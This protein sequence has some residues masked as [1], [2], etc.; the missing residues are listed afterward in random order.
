MLRECARE[1]KTSWGAQARE[2]AECGGRRR[3][4]PRETRQ[5]ARCGT[6]NR[7]DVPSGWGEEEGG[8]GGVLTLGGVAVGNAIGFD[9]VAWVVISVDGYT[10]LG[11]RGSDGK[12]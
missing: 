9:R 11:C 12:V 5:P 2:R 10:E 6:T 4:V 3:G 1:K 7:N 8:W